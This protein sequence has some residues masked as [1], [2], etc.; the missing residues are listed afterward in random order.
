MSHYVSVG[1]KRAAPDCES[2][3]ETRRYKVIILQSGAEES[4]NAVAVENS[5]NKDKKAKIKIRS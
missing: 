4:K 2:C 3:P 5:D 1:R